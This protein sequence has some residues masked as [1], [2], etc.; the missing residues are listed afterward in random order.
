M[1][2]GTFDQGNILRFDYE[3]TAYLTN[4]DELDDGDWDVYVDNIFV[5]ANKKAGIGTCMPG[6]ELDLAP[7]VSTLKM[8][9]LFITFG[10]FGV[11]FCQ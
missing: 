8:N 4:P 5:D 3:G 9:E 2:S 10:F 1:V 6:H 7:C 11:T